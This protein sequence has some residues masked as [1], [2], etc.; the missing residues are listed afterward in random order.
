MN[1]EIN[2]R[3]TAKIKKLFALADNKGATTAEASV[4][5]K[6][7]EGL[8]RKHNLSMTELATDGEVVGAY[9]MTGTKTLWYRMLIKAVCDVF[10]C[11]TICMSEKGGARHVIIGS[12]S[13]RVTA[14]IVT[15]SLVSVISKE[16]RGKGSAWKESAVT[17]VKEQVRKIISARKDELAT[18]TGL[19]VIDL[20]ELN[21]NANTEY[22]NREFPNMKILAKRSHYNAEG[23]A[24]GSTLSVSPRMS[25]K[26]AL[27]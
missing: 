2:A 23:A 18:G 20:D 11:D 13:N 7:A 5:L 9:I 15:S 25:N 26:R 22:L 3:L 4:A 21:K 24:F 17:S 27:N 16:G 14:S 10:Y 19:A 12:E 1:N 8:L 6:M